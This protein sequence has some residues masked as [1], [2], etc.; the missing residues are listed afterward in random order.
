MAISHKFKFVDSLYNDC[1][2]CGIETE[3]YDIAAIKLIITSNVSKIHDSVKE[4][5]NCNQRGEREMKIVVV[6]GYPTHGERSGSLL[7]MAKLTQFVSVMDESIELHVIT[8]GNKNRQYKKGNVNVHVVNAMWLIIPFFPIILWSMG[9]KI[10]RIHP[11][12]LH[13][14]G[15]YPYTTI[16]ALLRH[17]YPTLLTVFSFSVNELAFEKSIIRILRK[18][19]FSIP[20][21]RY[22]IPRISHIIV[23]SRISEKFVKRWTNSKI[24]VV[25]E[26]IE[27]VKNREILLPASLNERPDI[28]IA[29]NFRKLKGIDILIKAVST[30]ITSIPDLKLYIAGSGEEEEKLK[31]MVRNLGLESHVNFLGYIS[32]EEEINRYYKACKI[33]VVPSRWDIEPFAPLDAAVFGKPAIVSE[34]CNSS[35]V[36][37]GKTGFVFK[38]EDVKGLASKIVTLL[39]NDKLRA[40]MGKAAKEKVVE[41]DWKEIA[42][43][44][45]EIYKL[46]IADFNNT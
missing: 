6:G 41:Y 20:N 34:K 29:V 5:V 14:S 28:F 2:E 4:G 38:S 7:H 1:A 36:E 33:V 3:K 12:V 10:K 16:A 40:A 46:V 24:Y 9:Q 27:T 23:Q 19:L 35:L 13:A 8:I 45:V 22:V 39:T 32:D 25:P 26:G 37:D 42:S 11:D 44:T 30:V 17:A 21:E 31:S 43:K 15:S 18:V